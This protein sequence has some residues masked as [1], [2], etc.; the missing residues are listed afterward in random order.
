MARPPRAVTE[1]NDVPLEFDDYAVVQELGRG[2]M[3]RVFLAEDTV[4]ARMVAIKFIGGIEPDLA[5]RRRFLL[6]A[7]AV[8]R[9]QHPNVVAVYRVGE[10][11]D[12]PYIVTELVRGHALTE[13]PGPMTPAAVL[14]LAIALARGLAAAHRR[15]VIHCD[16]KP[17]NVMVSED[18]VAKLVDFGLARVLHDGADAAVGPMVGTPEYMAPEVWQGHAP[19]RRSDVYALGAVVYELTH[20]AAPFA[21]V[22]VGELAAVVTTRDAPP[23]PASAEPGLARVLARCLARDPADRYASGEELREA[24]EQLQAAR[25]HVLRIGENP[26][27]GLRAFDAVHRGLFFGRGLEVGTIVERLRSE[28]FVIAA[29]DSGVGKSSLLRAGVVPAVLDG[30]LGT[31]RPWAAFTLTPGRKPLT[32]LA[33]ALDTPELVAR[34]LADPEVLAR[35]LRLRAADRDIIVLIDQLEEL[36]TLGDP[37]E[38]AALDIGLARIS[39]GISGVRLVASVRA[40]F[41][42]RIAALPRLGRELARLLCF[43]GPIPPER[44]RDVITGP[45]AATGVTFESPAM[46]DEL[47]AAT[48]KAGSGGLP[49]LSFALAE[50]WEARERDVGVIS[51][52]ALDAMGGVAGALARHGDAVLAGIPAAGRP[53]ARRVLLRLVTADGTRAR[54]SADELA[55]GSGARAALDAIVR[56][57]LV[58]VHDGDAGVTYELA[59]EV[60][61]QG[62]ETLRTWLDADAEDRACRE[63]LAAAAAIWERGG[64]RADHTWRGEQ[65]A[66]ARGLDPAHLSELELAFVLASARVTRRGRWLWRGGLGAMAAIAVVGVGT[67]HVLTQRRLTREVDVE[68]SAARAALEEARATTATSRELAG[69]AFAS[70][71]RE[72]LAGGEATWR[73]QLAQTAA[74]ERQYR[75]AMARAD[76]AFAKDPSRA[77]VEALLAE[78]LYARALTADAR[79][80]AER[81]DEHLDRLAAYDVDGAYRARWD[82][83]GHLAVHTDPEATITLEPGRVLGHGDAVVALPPGVYTLSVV[84]PGRAPVRAPFAIPRAGDVALTVALPPASAVPDGFAYIP[85][86]RFLYGSSADEDVRTSFYNAAP[87]HARE[88]PAYL[89][90][91][92]EVTIT[93]WLEFVEH[94]PS[95]EQAALLPDLPEKLT[96][97]IRIDRP[98]GAWQLAMQPMQRAYAATWG[99]PIVYAGR[100]DHVRQ[101]WRRFPVTGI[102]ATDAERF[103]AWLDATGRVPGARLCTEVEWERAGRGADGRAFPG[104][105]HLEPTEANYDATYGHD[106]MGPDEVGTHPASASP[107]GILDMA[108]NAIEWTRAS[109]GDGYVVRGGS[110]FHDR[111]TAALANRSPINGG[112][113][114]AAVGVR[115]CATPRTAGAL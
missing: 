13:A 7:R 108:G 37:D 28:P 106:A 38:V 99:E 69:R 114:D 96:G 27:R 33:T 63:R 51:Q 77:D 85:A 90:A 115:L 61:I 24:F 17:G 76:A 49:L 30:A 98:A 45:A 16:I 54:R 104:G 91:R 105:D 84:A 71:D 101:D 2:Q 22:P 19:T 95:S 42:S 58:V 4:L 82:A 111:K 72:D 5:A 74:A 41:L 53:D 47:V 86:G 52:R 57:R 36:V 20:G 44:L 64:K 3:G 112:A 83:P 21:D 75:R 48:A 79:G 73:D 9:I 109:S 113:R 34:V 26:Y 11:A 110:Y 39:E 18:G 29:G 32:A 8:A 10:L 89:I 107:F 59:H 65:L 55:L 56:G 87:L 81:R 102:T 12:R 62:W 40:D 6:E 35:E 14:A 66:E 97:G 103:A 60:L 67:Q 68:V 94:Q 1:E 15:G 50:L 70:F 100:A 78:I 92:T 80:D 25:T 23:L 93:A 88:T 31:N 43:V 46:V